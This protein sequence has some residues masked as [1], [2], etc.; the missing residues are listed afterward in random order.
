MFD[1]PNRSTESDIDATPLEPQA[2]LGP[3]KDAFDM[4]E[5]EDNEN[6]GQPAIKSVHEL[7]RAGANNRFAD[8]MDD[9]LSRIGTPG[10]TI[11]TMRRNALCELT[12]KL[13]RNEFLRQFR[14]HAS[15]DAVVREIG[16][17]K[18]LVSGFALVSVLIVF[19]NSGS[20]PH[21][22]RQL[23]TEGVGRLLALLMR[24]DDDICDIAFQKKADMSRLSRS[25]L[26]AAKRVVQSL[27]IWHG[28]E[29]ASVSPKNVALQLL[30]V[31]S[32]RADAVLLD[33]I[34]ADME[35]DLVVVARF[36][37]E[38]GTARDINYALTVYALET[39][40][41]AGVVS[42]LNADGRHAFRIAKLLS[43]ALQHWPSGQPKLDWA[44]LKLAINTTNNEAE[45]AAFSDADL[46]RQLASIIS[47]GFAKV[48]EAES[49]G[50]L[51]SE[52]YDELLLTL[53][54]IIN[55]LEH[56]ATARTSM[57]DQTID[58]LLTPWLDNQGS[59]SEVSKWTGSHHQ[60]DLGFMR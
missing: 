47:G 6:P 34:M 1:S 20:A 57:D 60:S 44:I 35:Q 10:K 33:K 17:E 28:Y 4:D 24:F 39:Q 15:R 40:S 16:D 26:H 8:E 48:N 18:D 54:V 7:R 59:I 30:M 3:P 37:A 50:K 36:A 11:N 27:P 45:A 55:I 38:E 58:K 31:L 41:S 56:C 9:L 12:Q 22:L 53:G 43:R 19:L 52:A 29:L 42:R 25:S 2:L 23:T 49:S 32:S 5:S 14:D 21:L 51:E 46:L 13:Q